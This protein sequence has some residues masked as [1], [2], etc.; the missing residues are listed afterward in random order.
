MHDRPQLLNRLNHE[1]LKTRRVLALLE[2]E[3]DRIAQY[4]APDAGLLYEVLG[5]LSGPM[6]D[7]HHP[8]EDL[9][10]GALRRR[11]P[12]RAAELERI[13][14]EHCETS[15]LIAHFAEASRYLLAHLDASPFA[16]CRAARQLIAFERHHMR[17][18]EMRFFVYAGLYLTPDDWSLIEDAAKGL[19]VLPSGETAFEHLGDQ[20]AA[21]KKIA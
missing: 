3:V 1:H 6:S 12:Y 8:I 21:A 15:A 16:F 18:E 17:R 7:L 4:H 10:H 20:D 14:S 11:A 2:Q 9:V 5:Y 13:A 19:A